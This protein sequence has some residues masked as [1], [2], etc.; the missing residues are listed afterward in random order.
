MAQ[1]LAAETNRRVEFI[2]YNPQA[3]RYA[4]KRV[5]GPETAPVKIYNVGIPGATTDEMSE[6][7]DGLFPEPPSLI[8]ASVGHNQLPPDVSRDMDK[9]TQSIKKQWPATQVLIVGQNPAT[10]ERW[11]RQKKTVTTLMTWCRY[12]G[13]PSVSVFEA[14][15]ETPNFESLYVD[16]LHVN[17][18]GSTIWAGVVQR[19][20]LDD[21]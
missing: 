16:L 10:G 3:G 2:N 4:E 21:A 15:A 5:Y 20:L 12:W 1:T 7:F 17:E 8:V 14:I 11:E 13:F 6:H 19:Y 18:A 9:F